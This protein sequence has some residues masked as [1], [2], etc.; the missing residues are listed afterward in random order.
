MVQGNGSLDKHFEQKINSIVYKV[1]D[2]KCLVKDSVMNKMNSYI[3]IQLYKSC[4][5]PSLLFGSET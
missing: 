4:I 2:I 1:R 3:I 5:L